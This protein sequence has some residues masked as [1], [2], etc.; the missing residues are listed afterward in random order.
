MVTYGWQL[1]DPVNDELKT[2]LSE[3]ETLGGS[4][5]RLTELHLP[6]YQKDHHILW[7]WCVVDVRSSDAPKDAPVKHY[8]SKPFKM[9]VLPKDTTV[10]VLPKAIRTRDE[11]FVKVDGITSDGML[12]AME[13]ETKHIQCRAIDA[14]TGHVIDTPDITFGWDWR[15]LDGGRADVGLISSQVKTTRHEA[16]MTNLRSGTPIKGRCMVIKRP[17]EM[18][19]KAME[20]KDVD[21]NLP[22]TYYSD[23]FFF[24]VEPH[25]PASKQV[26]KQCRSVIATDEKIIVTLNE[27]IDEELSLKANEDAEI[28]ASVKDADGNPVEPKGFSF[29]ISYLSG[30]VAHVGEISESFAFDQRTG[31]LKLSKVQYP[32]KPIK[33]RFSVLMPAAEST[34]SDFG[35]GCSPLI[36]RSDYASVN[37][38]A[39]ED[40]TKPKWTE[41]GVPVY[42][43][44]Q[45]AYKVRINGLD[46]KGNALGTPKEPMELEC[47]V[48][49]KYDMEAEFPVNAYTWQL[50]DAEDQP[51]NPG[52]LADEVEI[53]GG[54]KLKLT[55]YRPSAEHDGIRGRCLISVSVPMPVDADI[56]PDMPPAQQYAS[57]YFEFK[58]KPKEGAI[59]PGVTD[60]TRGEETAEGR[61]T[62]PSSERETATE[63]GETLPDGEEEP[64]AKPE[65]TLQLD[66]PISEV[67]KTHENLYT[68]LARVQRPF[69]LNCRAIFNEGA[70]GPRSSSGEALPKLVW[71]YR[72]PEIPGDVPIPSQLFAVS[73]PRME[74]LNIGAQ[75]DYKISVETDAYSFRD[76]RAEF[77]CN[78]YLESDEK[79]VVSKVVYIQ[80]NHVEQMPLIITNLFDKYALPLGNIFIHST[81]VKEK[82]N[83]RIFD[84]DSRSRAYAFVGTS[85][86]LTCYVDDVDS[87]DRIEPESYQWEASVV[88]GNGVWIRT[89]GP[90]QPA[91][92][93]EGWTSNQLVLESLK[94]PETSAATEATYEFRCI[95]AYNTTFD[96][97]SRSFVLN[98]RQKPKIEFIRLDREK[99]TEA[100]LNTIDVPEDSYNATEDYQLGCKPEV[101]GS[102]AVAVWQ[103]ANDACTVAKDLIPKGDKLFL[104]A[105]S[106][107]Y[108]DE[109]LFR[110]QQ[111]LLIR[112]IR[113]FFICGKRIARGQLMPEHSGKYTCTAKNPYGTASSTIDVTVTEDLVRGSRRVSRIF[114]PLNSP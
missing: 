74:T 24:D 78:A 51:A 25:D 73:P 42:D 94:L 18:E 69:E 31:V 5:M 29:E 98:V 21:K 3:S 85:K 95:A 53:V 65:F 76:D 55:N 22:I 72:Q 61:E 26:E 96:T 62:T 40:A 83:V 36:Y 106:T 103:K 28:T 57:P 88:D 87:G 32:T 47:T 91:Q 67:Y 56:H 102:E 92:L 77:H 35:T 93:I 17:S 8:R 66:S 13:G 81:E 84:E 70:A 105:N 101:T 37:V 111:S 39:S 52:T 99:P 7:G 2:P 68:V 4:K 43:V 23:F 49:D 20:S 9:V 10:S 63:G 107:R 71:Y 58:T 33:L 79:P 60:E 80:K 86:T 45:K 110:C 114:I 16:T 104:F 6:D 27:A 30:Q 97:T 90:K 113:T 15:T 75:T 48:F 82:F 11:I 50:I 108:T 19:E 59:E 41:R 112:A 38:Q 34:D 54:K 100:V 12:R 89:S 44:N 109:G 64:A 14:L 46:D 1:I